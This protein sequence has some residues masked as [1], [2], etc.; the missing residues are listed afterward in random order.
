MNGARILLVVSGGIAAYKAAALT[1]T[2][3]QKGAIVDVILT[4][5]AERFI[6]PLTFAAL[7]ARPVYSSLWDAPE[8]IPHIRL[9]RD[10]EVAIVAPATANILAKLRAGI[11]DDLATTALLAARIP[12]L[13]APAMNAAMYENETTVENIAALRARGYEIVEPESGFLAEREHGVG[14]LASEER[15]L[16]AIAGA[17]ARRRS[18]AGKRVLITA[19]PTQEP[20][21]PVRFI[22]NASTG[23][24]G[25]ALA[26]EAARRGAD[27]TLLLGPTLL[28]PPYGVRTER[29]AAAHELLALALRESSESDVTI[30]TAAVADWRPSEISAEKRKKSDET[31]HVDLERTPDVLAAIAA[32]GASK[33]LVGFAAETNDHEAHAREKMERKALDAIVVNDVRGGAGFGLQENGL[34]LLVRSGARID[35]GRA[36]KRTLAGRLFDALEPLLKGKA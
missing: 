35:L 10:A 22:G 13:I 19:G 2:L 20:F 25:I 36:S 1:S 24:T 4:A 33:Y 5:D 18:L 26:E 9:V 28:A 11:A 14:R 31:L 3:V 17:R 21:D 12:V 30:A 16:E 29:F 8:R 7:T 23:A 34:V 6:A 15:L 27:V 32:A